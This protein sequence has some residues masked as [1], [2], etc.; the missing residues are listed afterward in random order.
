MSRVDGLRRL[1]EGDVVSLRAFEY[2]AGIAV[3]RLGRGLTGGAG[4]GCLQ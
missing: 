2:L 3:S 1:F 4:Q